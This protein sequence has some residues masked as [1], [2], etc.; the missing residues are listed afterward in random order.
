MGG[1][2]LSDDLMLHAA[3]LEAGGRSAVS[4][5]SAA[6]W[7]GFP[8]FTL[9]PFELVRLRDGTF[10]QGSLG[11]VH[12]TRRLPDTHV[13]EVDGMLITTPT[14]TLF[15]LAPR[16]YAD[17]TAKLID[18]AWAR[19]QT[20]GPL[21]HRTLRELSGRGQTGIT[22]MRE[23]L[24]VR[25]PDYI[26][27]ESNLEARFGELAIE[28]GLRDLRRQVWLGD[29]VGLIGRVD[30]YDDRRKIVF[31]IDSDL[32]HTSISDRERDAA[33]QL[34]LEAEGWRV[35]RIT[36]FEVW[37]RPAELVRRL[38]EVRGPRRRTNWLDRY[39]E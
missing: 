38:R 11:T 34:R 5:S 32:H 35:V 2:P 39:A 17:R 12:T 16:L 9:R 14:R 21:L 26:P 29:D 15:D 10:E 37:H 25:G 23:L 8:G 4:H 3:L 31:E 18:R 6:A 36:E 22:L 13:A 24:A 28:A 7:W 19:Y 27:P 30:F 33:R 1:V 20:S